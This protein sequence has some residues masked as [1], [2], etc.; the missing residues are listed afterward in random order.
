[1]TTYKRQNV[2]HLAAS[3]MLPSVV[4]QHPARTKA[5][6]VRVAPPLQQ[7]HRWRDLQ[8]TTRGSGPRMKTPGKL[9]WRGQR[10]GSQQHRSVGRGASRE[11]DQHGLKV[12]ASQEPAKWP[13]RAPRSD[14][15]ALIS[16]LAVPKIVLS[17]LKIVRAV[18]RI[19]LTVPKIVPGVLILLCIVYL[20]PHQMNGSVGGQSKLWRQNYVLLTVSQRVSA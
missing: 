14:P 7:G 9:A 8:N 15:S 4:V 19:A 6:K 13:K 1:M 10:A 12:Q 17:V 3:K 18:R 11:R 2:R 5:V 20:M 16:V